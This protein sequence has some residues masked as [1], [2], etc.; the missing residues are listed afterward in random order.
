M[1]NVRQPKALAEAARAG[2]AIAW[3][4]LYRNVQP[5]LR[6]YVARR[7]ET[8]YADD[9]VSDTM[10]RALSSIH[11]FEWG[12]SGFDGWVFGIARRAIAEHHHVARRRRQQNE[13][14]DRIVEG[15]E[16][17]PDEGLIV[18]D[19]HARVRGLLNQLAPNEQ[20][21]LTLRFAAG[22]STDQ[23]AA[24]LGKRPGAVRTAQSP[25]SPTCGRCWY[26][27]RNER[28]P[29]KAPVTDRDSK[30]QFCN[31]PASGPEVLSSGQRS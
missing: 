21:L 1:A 11:V 4:V 27:P 28:C 15:K 16:A 24:M 13:A 19:D 29:R 30:R 7:V 5:R 6:N 9:V 23:I 26:R 18:A 10:A 3:E 8:G 25:L 12:P 2:D 20:E 31:D 22:L 14:V 17:G